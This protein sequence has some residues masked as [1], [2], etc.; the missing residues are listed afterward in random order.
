MQRL[1]QCRA[2]SFI[3]SLT[4]KVAHHYSFKTGDEARTALFESIEMFYHRQRR[5]AFVDDISPTD[6]EQSIVVAELTVR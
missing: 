3:S 6:Y 1:R 2:E 5:P 4:N